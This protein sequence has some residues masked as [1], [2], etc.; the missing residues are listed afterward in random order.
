MK[1][2]C[3]SMGHPL[4]EVSDFPSEMSLNLAGQRNARFFFGFIAEE[5]KN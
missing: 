4:I 5:G 2:F 1:F 3:Y